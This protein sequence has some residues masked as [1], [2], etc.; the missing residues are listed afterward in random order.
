MTENSIN[1]D[2]CLESTQHNCSKCGNCYESG[3]RYNTLTKQY[4]R[5][6]RFNP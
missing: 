4:I 3:Y 5:Y 6:M 1:R 2:Y